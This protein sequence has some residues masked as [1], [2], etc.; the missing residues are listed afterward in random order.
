MLTGTVYLL[1]MP[2]LVFRC[3]IALLISVYP[4]CIKHHYT[5]MVE[6]TS[7]HSLPQSKAPSIR[8]YLTYSLTTHL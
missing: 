7:L 8:L 4:S 2:S 5:K 6:K 3:M 1:L